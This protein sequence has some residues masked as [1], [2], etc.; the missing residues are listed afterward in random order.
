MSYASERFDHPIKYRPSTAGN[1][2][3]GK[4]SKATDLSNDKI[5]SSQRS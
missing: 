5:G 1:P 2:G 4:L 3:S